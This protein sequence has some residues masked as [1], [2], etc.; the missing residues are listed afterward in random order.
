[1]QRVECNWISLR[2]IKSVYWNIPVKQE[3]QWLTAFVWNDGLY[4]FT[5]APFGQKVSGHAFVRAIKQILQPLK[6]FADAY[7]DNNS[8]FSY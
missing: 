1:M 4:E 8:V 5:R 3:H 6:Q 7:I 2:D